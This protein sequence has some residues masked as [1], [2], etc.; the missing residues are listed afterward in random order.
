MLPNFRSPLPSFGRIRGL[1]RRVGTASRRRPSRLTLAV[2]AATVATAVTGI[3]V[4]SVEAGASPHTSGVSNL[5][6]DSQATPAGA[7]GQTTTGQTTTAHAGHPISVHQAS[8]QSHGA[9]AATPE[10][11]APA[12]HPTQA[13]AAHPTATVAARPAP[14]PA[15][16]PPAQPY[17]FYDSATPSAIPAN[18]AMAAVYAT[19]Q[20]AASPS[21]VAGRPVLWI[22]TTGT[23]Y[24]ASALD[25][26]PGNVT[27][28]QAGA[29]AYNRLQQNPNATA[30]LYT[31][32][33]EWPQVQA[34]VSG[35]PSW[36]QSHIRWWI[37]D[38][39]GVPHILPGS[40]ATQ[41]Y[42]GQGYDESTALP[43]F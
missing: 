13:P 38:P 11:A 12:A 31:F 7:T 37:A 24:A 36:M 8:S 43:G 6:V 9:A 29:W 23:D 21:Q 41:W 42:W 22:D 16:A 27:P 17:N 4:A 32:Q 14:P 5:D 1:R 20:Y 34:A 33:N 40:E 35:L 39:T 10:P 30:I 3:T 19:G 18:N 15:P 26:E 2:A 25:V 28:S